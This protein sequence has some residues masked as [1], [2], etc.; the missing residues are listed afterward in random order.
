MTGNNAVF[1][2]KRQPQSS[3]VVS[4]TWPFESDGVSGVEI[5]ILVN[6]MLNYKNCSELILSASTAD[7]VNTL[8]MEQIRKQEGSALKYHQIY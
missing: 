4:S 1:L 2:L 6:I 7:R 8:K 5:P 3:R